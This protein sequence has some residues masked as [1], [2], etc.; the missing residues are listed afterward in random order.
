MLNQ[1]ANDPLELLS[2]FSSGVL[3]INVDG[4]HLLKIDAESKSLDVEGPRVKECGVPLSKIIQFEAGRKGVIGLL[5]G[6]RVTA[7]RLSEKGWRLTLYDN[8]NELVRIGKGTSSLTG[9]MSVKPTKVRKIL[10][11]L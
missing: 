6:S 5:N 8:G 7:S 1:K 11:S 2:F 9:H 10:K 3:S 4:R